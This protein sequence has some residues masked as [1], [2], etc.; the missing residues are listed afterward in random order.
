[1]AI[2]MTAAILGA[3]AIGG[4]ASL[5]SGA[6]GAGAASQAAAAQVSSADKALALQEQTIAQAREDAM[7]WMQ[8]GEAALNQYMAEIGI[9]TGQNAAQIEAGTQFQETPGYQF[10]VQEGEKGVLNNLAALGMRKSGTALKAL[11]R[12]REGLADQYYGNYLN[13]LGQASG[14]GQQQA[15]ATGG[16]TVNAGA[17]MANTIQD[18]GA[19]R[20]SGYVGSANAWTNALTGVA[21]NATNALGYMAYQPQYQSGLNFTPGS[22]NLY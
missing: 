9:D 14:M 3:A 5:A 22:G 19:A 2:G 10:N 18:A 17:N 8:A 15:T 16:L 20:A 12:F 6:I 1:M 13:R 11:T 7:P 21:N 4:V